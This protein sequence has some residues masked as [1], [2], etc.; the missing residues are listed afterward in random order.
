MRPFR[1]RRALDGLNQCGAGC[2][3]APVASAT[4]VKVLLAGM[5]CE[6]EMSRQREVRPRELPGSRPGGTRRSTNNSL[7][8]CARE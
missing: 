8:A 2:V 1:L 5:R 6:P 4:D 7:D 3:V